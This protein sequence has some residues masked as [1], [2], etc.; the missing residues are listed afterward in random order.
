M[1]DKRCAKYWMTIFAPSYWVI[2]VV[3]TGWTT[4]F[5]PTD[6][7]INIVSSYWIINSVSNASTTK[8]ALI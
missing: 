2:D 5:M 4:N 3:S 1:D 8:V 6:C 7:M